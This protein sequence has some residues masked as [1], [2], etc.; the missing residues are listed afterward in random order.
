MQQVLL[1]I[2]FP[3]MSDG[4]PIYGFGMMLFLAFVVCTWIA[5]R[6]ARQ[7]G[8]VPE[9]IQDMALW[10]FVLGI[11]GARLTYLLTENRPLSEFPKIWDGGLVFYGSILGGLVGYL[12]AYQFVLKKHGISNWKVADILAPAIAIGICLGRFGCF[13]NGCCYGHVNCEHGPSVGFPLS[14]PPRFALVNEGLQ[15]AAGFT[16]DFGS[17]NERRVGAVDPDSA[18]HASGLRPGDIIVAAGDR[19]IDTYRD[20]SDYLVHWK[21]GQ[22]ELTLTVERESKQVQIGPF[23]PLTLPLHPTQLYSSVGGLLLFLLVQAYYPLRRRDGEVMTLLM[24]AYPFERFLEESLRSDNPPLSFG[25]TFS[26]NVSA[27]L[28]LAGVGLA[29]WLASRPAQ[30]PRL[31]NA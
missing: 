2:P 7:E 10:V 27:G 24:L 5:T 31:A 15:T 23:I 22:K 13:L 21:R 30:Y 12:L 8:I 16:M 4:I 14:S 6:R 29:I 11:A 25:L 1:E 20:L 3:G 9:R 19:E 26:Q 28:L 18:A 17:G